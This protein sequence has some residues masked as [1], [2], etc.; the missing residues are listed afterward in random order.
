MVL[1]HYLPTNVVSVG[2]AVKCTQLFLVI[3]EMTKQNSIR[4]LRLARC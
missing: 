3:P 4:A 2:S 1:R